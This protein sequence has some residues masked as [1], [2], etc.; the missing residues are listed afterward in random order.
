MIKVFI[1]L[2]DG[3]HVGSEQMATLSK[4]TALCNVIE[5]HGPRH[6]RYSEGK[7]Y[8]RMGEFASRNRII[9]MCS[10]LPSNEI[11]F[12]QDAKV[13]HLFENNIELAVKRIDLGSVVAL[14][15]TGQDSGHI[16]M[17]CMGMTAGTM[18]AMPMMAIDEVSCRT[19]C[20]NRWKAA[21]QGMGKKIAFLDT[22]RRIRD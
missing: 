14:N 12:T 6:E 7:L 13:E 19:C 10:H 4:Q 17:A 3:D 16:Y 21:M 9:E 1:P 2:P 5:V 20:C 15:R 22:V 18:A 11:I 8:R